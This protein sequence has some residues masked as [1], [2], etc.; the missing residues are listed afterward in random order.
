MMPMIHWKARQANNTVLPKHL[1][2]SRVNIICIPN[3]PLKTL[4]FKH[5]DCA[6]SYDI[7]H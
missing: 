3:L 5:K 7:G 6:T 2:I 1:H 4:L